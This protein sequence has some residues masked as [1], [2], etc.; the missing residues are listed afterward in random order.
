MSNPKWWVFKGDPNSGYVMQWEKILQTPPPWRRFTLPKD[1]RD[2]SRGEAFYLDPSDPDDRHTIELVNASLY[3]R[4]PLLVTGNTGIGKSSLAYAV[5]RELKLKPVLC[6]PVTSHSVIKDGLYEYDAV[7]RLQEVTKRPPSEPDSGKRNDEADV[8]IG[9]YFTLK[10]LGTALA[11]PE[12]ESPRMLLVDELD[13][14]DM[15]LANNLLY[16]LEEGE[17]LIPELAR[18]EQKQAFVNQI[19]SSSPAEIVN[20]QVVCR[21]FPFVIMTSNGEREFP[22]PFLRRCIRLELKPPTQSKLFQIVHRHFRDFSVA[23]NDGKIKEIVAKFMEV[24]EKNTV[25]TDQ[26]L[27]AIY[28]YLVE[29]QIVQSS[30]GL[31]DTLLSS[32]LKGLDD[33][34]Y[35]S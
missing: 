4:R 35:L 11:N 20:G 18:A 29:K 2:N 8:N 25:S 31:E 34:T 21:N 32:L 30:N 1:K 17:F 5:Q 6:W 15:D 27:N 12:D 16:V 3:L 26:L 23:E 24:R 33:D 7:Q 28:M 22:Q 14:S 9:R 10:E 13:K 19:G